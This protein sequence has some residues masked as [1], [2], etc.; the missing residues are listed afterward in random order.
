MLE[1][2]WVDFWRKKFFRLFELKPEKLL[3]QKVEILKI[4]EFFQLFNQ[5]M[6]SAYV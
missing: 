1:V 3:G 5:N 4:R 2:F 6:Q